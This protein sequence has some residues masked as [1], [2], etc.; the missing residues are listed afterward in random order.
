MYN[1]G[2]LDYC[3]FGDG[4]SVELMRTNIELSRI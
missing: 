4:F 1:I 2:L 3:M